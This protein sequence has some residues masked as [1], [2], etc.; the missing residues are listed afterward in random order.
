[1]YYPF[2]RGKQFELL[3]L[4][5]MARPIAEWGFVP[6]IEPV[7]GNF[8]SLIRALDALIANKCRFILIGNPSIGELK[9]NNSSLWKEIINNQLRDYKN[10]SVGL[11]L[12]AEDT[13]DT[14]RSFFDKHNF[15]TSVIHFGF[16]D[17][18]G[19]SSI[20]ADNKYE[21][22]E[23]VFIEQKSTTLYRRHFKGKRVLIDDGFIVRKNKEYP[24]TEKF[25]ELYLTYQDLGFDAFGDF[26]IVGSEFKEGGGPAYAVA[27]HLTYA[28]PVLED[29]ISVKHY[30]SDNTSTQDDPGGKFLESLKK[31]T[32]DIQMP[33]SPILRTLAVEEYFKLYEEKHFPGLGYVKKL[34]MQHHMELIAHLLRGQV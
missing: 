9:K 23:H 34:S 31:L 17:G 4:R 15:P 27:I 18:K 14:A 32:S 33:R 22:S 24:L 13:L 11:H 6:I 30:V 25:S 8:S 20:I 5:E 16:P 12:G 26:L 3:M 10:Y 29:I 21:I 1:M 2:I 19:L 28:D 7:K